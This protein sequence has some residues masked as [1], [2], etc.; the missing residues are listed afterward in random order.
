[1]VGRETRIDSGP[2][3]VSLHQ[4][5]PEP[6][7]AVPEPELPL[8]GT[9][10]TVPVW[11]SLRIPRPVAGCHGLFVFGAGIDARAHSLSG[12]P[13]IHPGRCAALVASRIGSRRSDPLFGRSAVATLRG[14]ALCGGY[15]KR[16]HFGSGSSVPRRPGP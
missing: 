8:L 16:L 9:L 10:R 15:R 4:L 13:S 7:A 2:H 6:L 5:P 11:R 12:V 1:M 14:G 3:T